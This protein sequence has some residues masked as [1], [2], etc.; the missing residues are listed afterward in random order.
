MSILQQ[1]HSQGQFCVADFCEES[2]AV[3]KGM[4]GVA[5]RREGKD[6]SVP[7]SAMEG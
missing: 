3:R 7:Y 6:H 5:R 1:G 2:V 4:K